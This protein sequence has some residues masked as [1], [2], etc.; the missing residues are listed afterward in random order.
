MVCIGT[1]GP[2]GF[3]AAAPTVSKASKCRK[4]PNDGSPKHGSIESFESIESVVGIESIESVEYTR[5]SRRQGFEAFE[6][7]EAFA[8]RLIFE[9]FEAFEASGRLGF[10]ASEVL[11]GGIRGV[12]GSRLGA[13]EACE[14]ADPLY[15]YTR[16]MA[17][18]PP[19]KYN[20]LGIAEVTCEVS[21]GL[22]M[23]PNLVPSARCR[24]AAREGREGMLS[25]LN[26]VR[27]L[28]SNLYNFCYGA[29]S[30]GFMPNF[31]A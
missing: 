4:L 9:A 3:R 18:Y 17:L 16:C 30:I 21:A 15:R 27:S 14:A 20:G 12:W 22:D 6:A 11:H 2:T 5:R 29:I 26:F 13:F 19:S 8:R 25:M 7:F 24:Y 23:Q 28:G 1:G 10:E 31:R